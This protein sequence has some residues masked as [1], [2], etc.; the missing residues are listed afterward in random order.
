MINKTIS[1]FI[2]EQTCAGICCVD[3]T[4]KPYCFSCFY[5]VNVEK[6]LLYF[7]SSKES[8]H[9]TLLMQH[10][11]VAGTVLPDKLHELVVKGLQFE[12]VLLDKEHPLAQNAS[13]NYHKANPMA[14]AVPGEIWTIQIDS[15]KMTDSTLGFGKKISWQREQENQAVALE[16]IN[17]LHLN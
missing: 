3:E 12:G 8:H 15:I 16:I 4:G 11:F 6:G 5:A 17:N 1:Q 7:K 14:L 10:P 2:K 13:G 9:A